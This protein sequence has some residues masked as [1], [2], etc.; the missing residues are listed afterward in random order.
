MREC[1]YLQRGF[2]EDTIEFH[3]FDDDD[4]WAEDVTYLCEELQSIDNYEFVQE[5]EVNGQRYISS[6][7]STRIDVHRELHK[8]C[9]WLPGWQELSFSLLREDLHLRLSDFPSRGKIENFCKI[10]EN[11]RRPP[12]YTRMAWGL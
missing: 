5:L 3:C 9:A 11:T 12:T 7:A 2:L 6:G 8:Q 4:I 1:H 10:L